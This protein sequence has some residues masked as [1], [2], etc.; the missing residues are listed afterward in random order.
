MDSSGV[1]THLFLLIQST[2]GGRRRRYYRGAPCSKRRWQAR[3]RASKAGSLRQGTLIVLKCS[4]RASIR[5]DTMRWFCL[6]C[7]VFKICRE[8]LQ[9]V[10]R[11]L[12]MICNNLRLT[13]SLS[14]SWTVLWR[15]KVTSPLVQFYGEKGNLK[16]FR[17]TM[18]DVIYPQVKTWLQNKNF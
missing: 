10:T 11:Q 12:S 15:Y 3:V 9:I 8:I 16:T 2:Q 1:R 7:E 6:I 14:L 4:W 5:C 18:S 13:C 17:G